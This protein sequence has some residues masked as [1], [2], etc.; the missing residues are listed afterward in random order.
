M[1]LKVEFHKTKSAEQTLKINDYFIHSKYNPTREAFQLA[2]KNYIPH[3]CHI[4]F[5]YGCGHLVNALIETRQF[6]ERIIVVDPLFN[7]LIIPKPQNDKNVFYYG[8]DALEDFELYLGSMIGQFD[9]KNTV[10]C[11]PNY[12]KLF[13]NDYKLLLSKVKDGQYRNIVNCVTAIKYATDWHKNFLENLIHL[14]KDNSGTVLN[15]VYSAPAVVVSGGPSLYKQLPLLKKFREKLLV[16]CAGSS[17]NTLL[18]QGIEPDYTVTI[19]GGKGN[20]NHFRNLSLEHSR[21]VYEIQSHPEIR[22]VFKQ[23]GYVFQLLG[24]EILEKFVEEKL[25][26]QLLTIPSGNSVAHAAYH[27]ACYI[28]TGPVCLIGQDLAYTDNLT[29]AKGNKYARSIDEKFIKENKAFQIEGYYGG[30]VW[31]NIV[32]D[33]MRRGFEIFLKVSPK[34]NLIYN[35]TEGGA[36]IDGMGQISF[37]EFCTKYATN[38]TVEIVSSSEPNHQFSITDILDEELAGYITLIDALN[39]GIDALDSNTGTYR[40]DPSTIKTLQR[41]DKKIRRIVG[42]LTIEPLINPILINIKENYLPPLNETEK[43]AFDRVYTQTKDLYQNL[44]RQINLAI[45]LISEV[46]EKRKSL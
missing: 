13:L 44:L 39:E 29:H 27:F 46:I 31:T 4:I 15:N 9:I 18:S 10:I 3:Y 2:E 26:L 1:E 8:T 40:F 5:G 12:D 30:K 37:E 11:L 7:E 22:K 23:Q 19:D 6:N 28:T 21:I 32:L 33:S 17:I 24:N 14:E 35:C 36:K 38:A 41:T 20:L 34:E 25:K 45:D 42:E 16:I 43:Q